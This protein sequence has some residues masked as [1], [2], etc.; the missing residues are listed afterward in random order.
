MHE[1]QRATCLLY[2]AGASGGL[3]TSLVARASWA[4]KAKCGCPPCSMHWA[5][6]RL[7]FYKWREPWNPCPTASKSLKLSCSLSR[8]LKPYGI[9]VDVFPSNPPDPLMDARRQ[10]IEPY[11]IC[12]GFYYASRIKSFQY[13]N[14][15]ISAFVER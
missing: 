3:A 12:S 8:V 6:G 13:D 11:L 9:L 15:L 5:N 1:V 2:F 7:R 10:M 4:H 14:P